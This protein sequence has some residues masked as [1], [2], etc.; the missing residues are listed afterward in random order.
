MRAFDVFDTNMDFYTISAAYLKVGE[1]ISVQVKDIN[2]KITIKEIKIAII[3]AV[4]DVDPDEI[5]L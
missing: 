3:L 1:I 5:D 2:N 4:R